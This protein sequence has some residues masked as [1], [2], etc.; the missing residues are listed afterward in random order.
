MEKRKSAQDQ[1][2]TAKKA[3][4]RLGIDI[5]RLQLSGLD[6]MSFLVEI[7]SSKPKVIRTPYITRLP[8]SRQ[9]PHTSTTTP[10]KKNTSPSVSLAPGLGAVSTSGCAHSYPH[11]HHTPHRHTVDAAHRRDPRGEGRVGGRHKGPHSQTPGQQHQQKPK[12]I[13][14]GDHQPLPRWARGEGRCGTCLACPCKRDERA[15]SERSELSELSEWALEAGAWR[16]ACGCAPTPRACTR[17]RAAGRAGGSY[18]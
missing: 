5:E 8:P 11:I 10:P 17:L 16:P 9:T 15:L 4:E 12:R 14:R 7:A 1:K 2:H 18:I 13:G 6:S 3:L